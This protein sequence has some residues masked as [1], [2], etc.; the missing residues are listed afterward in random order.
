M[1]GILGGKIC[2]EINNMGGIFEGGFCEE[3]MAEI[4][5]GGFCVEIMAW[6]ESLGLGSVRRQ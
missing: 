2:E 4:L 6:M 5:G 3:I 1:A